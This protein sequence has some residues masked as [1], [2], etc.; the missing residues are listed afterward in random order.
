M[1]IVVFLLLMTGL[2]M[3]CGQRGALYL[4]DSPPPGVKPER[5]A[6]EKPVPAPPS[7]SD[8]SEAKR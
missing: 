8:G 7:G 2:T 6:K 3:G 1:R 5:T 4:R